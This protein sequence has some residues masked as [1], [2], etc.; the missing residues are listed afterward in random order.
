[1]LTYA[2]P[3]DLADGWIIGDLPDDAT[4]NVL[5]RYASQ[6]VRKATRLDL[7]EV[8][9]AGLPTEPDVIEAMRDATCVHVAMW[10]TAGINPAGGAVGR[11][12]AIKSQT[13]DGGSTTYMD[14][15]S[16]E[17]I[18]R[19]LEYLCAAGIDILRNAGLASTRPCTW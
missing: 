1:M 7:Y 5:I 6:L 10:H 12:V 11:E 16:A 15:P 2:V 17:E 13:A 4:A 8:D 3:D 18:Q 14:A 19:S 9:P